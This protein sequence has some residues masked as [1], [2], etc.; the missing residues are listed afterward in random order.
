MSYAFLPCID[1]A[2]LLKD[3]G[4]DTLHRCARALLYSNSAIKAKIYL[5]RSIQTRSDD[6]FEQAKFLY[7]LTQRATLPAL[8]TLQ[9]EVCVS[10]HAWHGL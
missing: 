9:A 4:N 10:Y 7:E 1:K 8:R 3:I 5:D 2:E 6:W